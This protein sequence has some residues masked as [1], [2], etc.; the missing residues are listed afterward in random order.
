M[1]E[2]YRLFHVLFVLALVSLAHGKQWTF[3][4][5]VSLYVSAWGACIQVHR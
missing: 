3:S 1:R 5:G 4:D 2:F